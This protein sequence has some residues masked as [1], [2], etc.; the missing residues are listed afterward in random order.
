MSEHQ[1]MSLFDSYAMFGVLMTKKLR[2]GC[3]SAASF[4]PQLLH[5]RHVSTPTGRGGRMEPEHSAIAHAAEG[6][7]EAAPSFAA[8]AADLNSPADTTGQIQI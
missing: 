5:A 1:F 7:L 3:L 2:F 8:A 4:I 6:G